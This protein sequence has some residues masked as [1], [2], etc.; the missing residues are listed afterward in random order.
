M[1]LSHA[2]ILRHD[3]N[4]GFS[5][6]KDGYVGILGDTIRY[7]G[8]ERP[9]EDYG[10]EKALSGKLLM[11]GLYNAHTHTPMTLLRGVGSGLPLDRWLNEAIFPMEAKLT[12]EDI[13]AGTRLALM[14]LLASGVV[15]FSDMYYQ[16]ERTAEEVLA[17]G[18]KANL[19][20]PIL[21]FDPDEPYERNVRVR[22]S[23]AFFRDYNGAGNGRLVADFS[24][25]AEYT[26]NAAYV[27]R[28]AEDCAA[29]GAR[30]H[31][32]L[33]ETKRE[34]AACKEKYGKTPA[35]WF[36]DLG[37]FDCPTAA[38]HCVWVEDGDIALFREKQVSC[39]H[40]P[41]SNMKLGSGLMPVNKLLA[42]GVNV[43]LGTDGAASNNNLNMFEEMHLAALLHKGHAL[44]AT[45]LSL[46]DVLLMATRNGA[47][48]Q[49]RAGCG[50]LQEGYKADLIAIDLDRPH[51]VPALDIPALLVYSA[52]ASDVCL[53]MTDGR[54][55]YE[56][57]QYLTLDAE[58][59]MYDAKNAAERLY[60][61]R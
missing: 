12:A 43:A 11:P 1:L 18:I 40:N 50:L 27:R 29:Y 55:L 24:I 38:A 44:D 37:V 9:P 20:S 57:G 22:Q 46:E 53:T 47:L 28:Y 14:E 33:S 34:H 4:N 6:L 30:M 26:N 60:G 54:I 42:S 5:V 31:L 8:T 23:L 49:G 36:A 61:R 3:P 48:A 58:R 7:I 56:N 17:C 45:V 19:N 15:S 41:A 35:A 13:R 39:V 25:H 59:T 21:C 51:L 52:Q 32:H 2:D 16:T 10:E